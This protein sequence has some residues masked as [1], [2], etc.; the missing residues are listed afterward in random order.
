MKIMFAIPISSE[1]FRITPDLGLGYLASLARRA[2]H[3]VCLVDCTQEKYNYDDFERRVREYQPDV[4]ALKLYTIDTPHAKE[5]IHRVR[6]VSSTIIPVIGGPH[7]SMELP[8]KVFEHIPELDFAFAGEGEPGF[9]PFLEQLE[10]ASSDFDDIA[11]LR[12]RDSARVIHAN[13]KMLVEDLDTLPLPAWDLMDPRRYRC[14][15]SFMNSRY[16]AAPV[17]VTRGCPYHCTYCGAHLITSRTIRMR[18]VEN[19]IEELK[20]LSGK[21]GVRSIDISDDNFAYN[22]DFVLE[23]CER[24]IREQLDIGW[25]CPFG[26]RIDRLDKEM[27]RMM[28]RSGCFAL[29]VGVE[30]G[31]NRILSKIKKG[32]TVETVIEKVTM[33]KQ[34]SNIKLQ[35]FFMMG[36]PD[37]TVQ[38]IEATIKLACSLPFDMAV[39]ATLRI[40]PGTE[41]HTELVAEGKIQPDMDYYEYGLPSFRRSYS[42]IPDDQL[43]KLYRKAYSSFY[44]RPKVFLRLLSEIRRWGQVRD[45]QDGLVR[46]VRRRTQKRPLCPVPSTLEPINHPG[47]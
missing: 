27:I 37:E 13:K 17:S 36:F 33:I 9:L 10:S 31:S 43:F 34:V 26:V 30:S 45:P 19:I 22:R 41:L 7:P 32:L 5:M 47:P 35:G 25:N 14:G 46:L 44:F 1:R 15:G 6:Q 4:L 24:L 28:E 2:G 23:F 3:Q 20:L 21:Y 18:G 42:Q 29:S 38:E 16:P 39:F 8:E 12:W 40:V 11:G